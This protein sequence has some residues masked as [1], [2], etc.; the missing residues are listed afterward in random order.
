MGASF[1]RQL[2]FL[3]LPFILG[4]AVQEVIAEGNHDRLAAYLLVLAAVVVVEYVGL[5]GWMAWSNLAE[6]RLAA[7]LREQMLSAVLQVDAEELDSRSQGYGDLLSR[8]VDDVDTVLVWVHGLATWVVIGTTVVVLVPALAAIDPVL[9]AV[10]LGCAVALAAVNIVLPARFR[11]RV[12]AFARAQGARARSVEEMTAAH[13]ALRGVGGEGVLIERHLARSAEVTHRIMA[14]ARIRSLWTASGDAVP[15]VGIAVGLAVGGLAALTGRID[16]G[17][18]TTFALWMG[19]VQLA[20]N[21]IVLR[22]GDY[23]AARVSADRIAEV[24]A[25]APRTSGP[26]ATPPSGP[27]RLDLEDL[28]VNEAAPVRLALGPGEW[29]LLTGPTGAGK[30][31]MLRAVAGM[32]P[33]RGRARWRGTALA[34]LAADTRFDQVALVPQSPLLLHGTVRENLHLAAGPLAHAAPSDEELRDACRVAGFEPVLE[35]LPDGL[36]TV[37]GERGSTLSGGERQRLA[38]AR[39]LLRRTPVLLLD[40]VTSALDTATEQLVL[41]RLRTATADTVVLWTGHRDAVRAR[42]DHVVDLGVVARG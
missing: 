5:C 21:A 36:D 41:D 28:A 29:G 34:E 33:H 16:V 22:L 40:D 39:A 6:A 12:G 30:S 35:R 11:R 7:Q 9:L 23:G 15:Q 13:T 1:V 8:A 37:V 3:A 19:T 27:V 20:T 38:L 2:A 26:S 17:Q 10:A 4:R 24:L 31:T 14:V 42:A 18:L 32:A 25:L